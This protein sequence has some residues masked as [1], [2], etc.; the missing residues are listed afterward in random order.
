MSA[1]RERAPVLL[2]ARELNLG[3]SERQL[4]EMVRGLDRDRF[5][6]H[7]GCF[8]RGGIRASEIEADG[9]PLAEFPLRSFRS[10]SDVWSS[11]LAL[12]RYVQQHRIRVVHAFDAPTN[13]FVSIA[14]CFLGQT[15]VLTSQRSHRQRR[16]LAT[17]ASLRLADRLTDGVVVNCESVRAELVSAERVPPR[18][19]HLCYNGVDARRFRRTVLARS[20]VLPPHA[21]VIGTV[22][23]FR[24]EKGLST[25]LRAFAACCASNPNLVLVMVGDGQERDDLQ[26]QARERGIGSRCVFQPA[27]SDVVPW[28]SRIDIFVLPSLFEAFSNA[29]MEAMA[30]ECACIA[31]RV[32]GNPELVHHEE[33]GLLFEKDD[34]R[35]LVGQLERLVA[36]P[37]LRQRLGQQAA[38]MIGSKFSLR[39]AAARLG[40]I[41]ESAMAAQEAAR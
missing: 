2:L 3:G 1:A 9:I 12:R 11:V 25:L 39:V 29:L 20:D 5:V 7:T 37:D 32:G 33:T 15:A 23:A 28:L 40:A 10:P 36:D 8:R 14:A 35:S 18:R 27:A 6:V 22:C 4:C 16:T 38:A 17:R 24:P 41:Y 21:L 31:S 19:I 26:R 34:V 13:V 30:C